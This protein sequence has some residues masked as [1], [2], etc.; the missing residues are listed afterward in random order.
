MFNLLQ[1]SYGTASTFCNCRSIKIVE[2]QGLGGGEGKSA[3]K[4]INTQIETTVM[5]LELAIR[6]VIMSEKLMA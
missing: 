1:L 2:N 3:D 5:V 4:A 6:I